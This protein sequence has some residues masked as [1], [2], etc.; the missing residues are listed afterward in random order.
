MH[1]HTKTGRQ[2]PKPRRRVRPLLLV[3]L[4]IWA[5]CVFLVVDLFLNVRALDGVRPD[6]DWYRATRY[7]AHKIS[8]RT[9]LDGGYR[10]AIEAPERLDAAA[11]DEEY[12]AVSALAL[13]RDTDALRRRTRTGDVRIRMAALGA[14]VDVS[15]RDARPLLVAIATEQGRPAL[16]RR[17]AARLVGRTGNGALAALRSLLRADLPPGIL[18]GAALGLSRVEN[19][20]GASVALGVAE[21]FHGEVRGAACDA[22][23]EMEG[24][25]ALHV[26]LEAAT[27]ARRA[28]P[29]RAA[30]CR[31]LGNARAPAATAALRRILADEGAP[32]TLREAASAALAELRE[33]RD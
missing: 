4:W 21:R 7:A 26:L 33:R 9:Y 13:T 15:G 31:G 17:E 28:D 6:S 25:A 22:L 32:A 30:A 10:E 18:A 29:I 8:G 11:L 27:N 20:E 14:I 16:L 3:L 19:G 5:V 23:S 12:V 24:S 1:S 2:V